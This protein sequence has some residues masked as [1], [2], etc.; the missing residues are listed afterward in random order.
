[1]IRRRRLATPLTKLTLIGSVVG[2]MLAL[3][4][5]SGCPDNPYDANTWI[6]K[7][8][9]PKEFDRAVTELEHLCNPKAIPALGKAWERNSK[10]QR[11]LQVVIDLARPLTPQE[12]DE[13]N[14]TDYMKQ[15]RPASWDAA[16][17]ILKDAIDGLELGSQRSIDGAVKAAE[18]LGE[19]QIP[20]GVN[21]LIDAVNRKMN[22]KDNAQRVRLTA[23]AALGKYKDKAA[24]ITLANVVRADTSSQPPQIVGAAINALGDMKTAE[25]IPVLLESMYRAPLFFTQVRRALVAAGPTVA[26][27]LRKILKHE[28]PV[29]N[30][31]FKDK[32]LDKYCGD[33]GD[34]KPAE[35]KD[36]S[37]MDYYASI[38]IGDLYDVDSVPVLIEALKRPAI[39]AYYSDWNEGPPAQN[40]ELDALRKIGSPDAAGTVLAI[41]SDTKA[42]ERLRGI[43]LS[44]Y[45]FVSTD[46]SEKTGSTSGVSYLGALAADNKASE[47]L[48]LPASEAYAR[49]ASSED[50][51]KVLR[52]L[53]KKYAEASQKAR[54]EADAGP[55]K[56]FD[57]AG[58]SIPYPQRDV[59]LYS[60]DASA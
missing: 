57:A 24:V 60:V 1:M 23:I 46:G 32:K 59:H 40:A 6:E 48:R 14:C 58:I 45:G 53:A 35:C 11:V 37:A 26:G 51:M 16:L 17:P 15:G 41:A 22:P 31:L 30:D 13:K 10:P 52:D 55:K 27:E 4:T 44:V 2:T 12:A 20:E 8:N 50:D 49:V 34:A 33:K 56:E 28:H 25:A 9:S 39:A 21:I 54:K 42:D 19:A 18:A 7:L 29:I 36:V 43:A 38:V 3:G 5:L 47:V